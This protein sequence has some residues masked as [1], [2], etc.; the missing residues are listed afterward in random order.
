MRIID[1]RIEVDDD[2]FQDAWNVAAEA[3]HGIG[4]DLFYTDR[5]SVAVFDVSEEQVP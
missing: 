4:E 1:I 3:A 5:Y 2:L